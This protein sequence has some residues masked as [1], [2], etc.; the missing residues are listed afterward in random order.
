[1]GFCLGKYL[2]GVDS[3]NRPTNPEPMFGFWIDAEN[4]GH[5][6]IDSNFVR[7]G[8]DGVIDEEALNN[9]MI[10]E[11]TR[12]YVATEFGPNDEQNRQLTYPFNS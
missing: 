3:E 5:I 2:Q 11:T 12:L 9:T 7:F 8:H 4:N 10:V 1:M 6:V